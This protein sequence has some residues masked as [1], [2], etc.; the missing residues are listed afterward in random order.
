M[1]ISAFLFCATLC[2][3]APSASRA[4]DPGAAQDAEAARE[5]LLKASDEIT[6]MQANS[7]NTRAAVDGVKNDVATLQQTVTKLQ[8]DNAAL[9]QQ[10]STLQAAFDQY[11][12]DQA[13]E[14]QQLIDN[15]AG[16]IAAS[17]GK[18]SKKKPAA[19][20]DTPKTAAPDTEVHAAMQPPAA[21]SLTPPPDAAATGETAPPPAP[22]RQKGYYHVVAAG[23]TVAD[24]AQA[25]RDQG[26]KVTS[27]QI[28]KA[29]GLTPESTL[30]PG[31]KL[32][33]PKPGT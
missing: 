28:R 12:A 5:K 20:I 30:K 6:N 18:T 2:L 29:N 24:I 4:Q 22:K 25:F 14:R 15:V 11:K 1:R 10:L 33:I 13:K 3:A 16:M 8:D 21:P 23:E 7:E 19:E 9:K 26:V 27:S 17:G 32:F 31:E